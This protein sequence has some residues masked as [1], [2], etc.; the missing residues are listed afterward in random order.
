MTP[1]DF[2][3]R[4]VQGSGRTGDHAPKAYDR[5]NQSSAS[6]L[7]FFAAGVAMIVAAIQQPAAAQSDPIKIAVFGFELNDTSAGAGIVAQDAV[8][9]ENLTK[10]TEEARRMLSASGRYS[11]VDTGTVAGE[12]TS[13]GGILRCGGCD[14]PLAKKLGADQSMVGVVTRVSRTEYTLHILVRDAETGEVLSNDSTGL[15]MGANYAWPRGVKRLLN[16]GVLSP[17]QA[18]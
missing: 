7:H 18:Q 3:M 17:Q 5:A 16:S 4:D 15:M 2:G 9:T 1:R 12:V 8:D 14:G 6:A 10:S 11:V 13:A